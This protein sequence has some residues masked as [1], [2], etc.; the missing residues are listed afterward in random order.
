[1]IDYFSEKFFDRLMKVAKQVDD[2][3]QE[4]LKKLE[5]DLKTAQTQYEKVVEQNKCLQKQVNYLE[6]RLQLRM[7]SDKESDDF[8]DSVFDEEYP[9][10]KE[11]A[12]KELKDY[13]FVLEQLPLIY[14]EITGGTLSKTTYF[15][16]SV[17]E[18]YNDSVERK[19]D[20]IDDLEYALKEISE[21]IEKLDLYSVSGINETLSTIEKIKTTIE[22]VLK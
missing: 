22:E 20:R 2:E 5:D 10:N 6:D 17:I 14:M 8:W 12:Y 4:N 7:S 13:Y 11:N 21:Y 9:F 1:M 18:A 15:A 19:L 3:N 16:S